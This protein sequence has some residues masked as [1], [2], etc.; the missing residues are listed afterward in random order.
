MH[1]YVKYN[2][3]NICSK[4]ISRSC[5]IS[6]TY[7]NYDYNY[8]RTKNLKD[9]FKKVCSIKCT[10]C[11]AMSFDLEPIKRSRPISRDTFAKREVD[12]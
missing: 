4:L 2:F 6:E 1:A 9:P 8:V 5:K 12:S 3:R 10:T 11:T 7:L